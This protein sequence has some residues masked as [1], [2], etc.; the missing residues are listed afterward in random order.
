[1]ALARRRFL[2]L[3]AVAPALPGITKFA[4]AQAYPSRPLRWIV[5]FPAGGATDVVARLLAQ[6]LTQRLGPPGIV[7]N[8]PG[9]RNNIAGPTRPHL[10]PDGHTLLLAAAAS[11]VNATLYKQLPFNFLRDIAPVAGIAGM[12]LV[13]E[14]SPSFPARTVTEFIAYARANP[15]R[16]NMASSGVGTVPHL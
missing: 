2:Q 10:P 15:G 13:M 3:A 12:P 11:A 8:R 9:A 14:V 1:M 5:G 6:W 16:L 4:A 7:A